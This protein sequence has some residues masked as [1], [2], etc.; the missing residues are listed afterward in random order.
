M[1]H[2]YQ[3]NRDHLQRHD[4]EH[5]TLR[6]PAFGSRVSAHLGPRPLSAY[7]ALPRSPRATKTPTVALPRSISILRALTLHPLSPPRLRGTG[8]RPHL[9]VSLDVHTSTIS[10]APRSILSPTHAPLHTRARIPTA[11]LSAHRTPLKTAGRVPARPTSTSPTKK[12][13]RERAVRGTGH[14]HR[15][16]APSAPLPSRISVVGG[17]RCRVWLGARRPFRRRRALRKEEGCARARRHARAR[18]S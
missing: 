13:S 15:C 17:G 1:Y 16:P 18:A 7:P 5:D 8:L 9:S 6:S 2:R 4:C 3:P 14:W 11:T 10:L 12:T